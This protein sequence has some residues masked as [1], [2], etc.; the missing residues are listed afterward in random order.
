MH[1]IN[2]SIVELFRDMV[3]S[4]SRKTN[5]V[6]QTAWTP[7]HSLALRS[8][9][10]IVMNQKAEIEVYNRGERVALLWLVW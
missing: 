7:R 2:L 1:L 8:D 6:T 10:G 3:L 5:Q 9:G 4:C